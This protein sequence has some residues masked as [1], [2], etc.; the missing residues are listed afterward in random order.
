MG[1]RAGSGRLDKKLFL[2]L[3][4]I[5]SVTDIQHGELRSPGIIELGVAGNYGARFFDEE[6]NRD[7]SVNFAVREPDGFRVSTDIVGRSLSSGLLFFRHA[8]P[9]ATYDS[10]VDSLGKEIWR[11]P[12]VPTSS[13]FGYI[14]QDGAPEFFFGRPDGSIEARNISGAVIW[15]TPRIGWADR[16]ELLD[17]R[18]ATQPSL[19]VDVSGTLLTLNP[20]GQIVSRR[21]PAE[22]VEEVFSDF[23]V[24]HW[25][26]VCQSDCLLVSGN[27]AFFLLSQDGKTVEAKLSPAVYAMHARGLSVRLN[28]T[29]SPLLAVAG[30]LPY[31]GGQWAG[32][33]ALHGAL[34]VFDARGNLVYHEVLSEPVEA[35]GV[36]PAADGKSDT[37]LVGGENKVWRYTA[38]QGNPTSSPE[39]LK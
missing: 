19:L 22:E 17:S 29:G 28:Q 9:A 11:T 34:Y 33:K 1:V 38:I 2:N 5:G 36:L 8:A 13:T 27:E 20:S 21:R 18:D 24:L 15:Q 10:L 31:Q 7:L 32:F 12:Y 6:G 37:L 30:S 25:P 14:G 26:T 4:N 3:D 23:S 39:P 16:C 35:L